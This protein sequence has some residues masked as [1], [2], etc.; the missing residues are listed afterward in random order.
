MIDDRPAF[1]KSYPICNVTTRYRIVTL[2]VNDLAVSSASTVT[3]HFKATRAAREGPGHFPDAAIAVLNL[4]NGATSY[5]P[6][7]ATYG[8]DV[9]PVRVTEFAS[10]YLEQTIEQTSS[11]QQRL[12]KRD[13]PGPT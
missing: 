6:D 8:T 2:H 13:Y 9:Y 10:G 1:A 11:A 4:T 7:A 3:L 5:L 12:Q